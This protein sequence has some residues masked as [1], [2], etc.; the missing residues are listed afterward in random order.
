MDGTECP[1]GEIPT[2]P[3]TYGRKCQ[4]PFQCKGSRNLDGPNKGQRCKCEPGCQHCAWTEQ[5]HVCFKCRNGQFLSKGQCIAACPASEASIGVSQ[6]GRFCSPV[7]LL[8]KSKRALVDGEK[9]ACTCPKG[10]A[11]CEYAPGNMAESAECTKCA[12]GRV[13]QPDG[14]CQR[15]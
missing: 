15:P 5:G 4:A 10:C 9:V 2:L 13:A 7:A 1:A 11:H 3:G 14:T 8:C 12:S 6:Y